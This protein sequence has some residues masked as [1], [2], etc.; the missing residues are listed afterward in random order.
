MDQLEKI[1][2]LRERLGVSYQDAYRALE[3]TNGEVV[4]ALIYLEGKGQSWNARLGKSL[5]RVGQII[6]R[7]NATRIRLRKGDRVIGEVPATVGVAGVFL[8]L[9]SPV[10]AVMGGLAA[11]AGLAGDY[12]FEVVKKDQEKVVVPIAEE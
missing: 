9:V 8:M 10:V 7:G 12:H 5:D 11:I 1:D 3:Q 4:Q 2:L 6:A